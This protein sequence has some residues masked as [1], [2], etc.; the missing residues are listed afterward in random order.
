MSRL[1]RCAATFALCAVAVTAFTVAGWPR[2]RHAYTLELAGPTSVATLLDL[3]RGEELTWRVIAEATPDAPATAYWFVHDDGRLAGPWRPGRAVQPHGTDR[4][5]RLVALVETAGDRP[6]LE[7][8]RH[9]P[10][11]GR[12]ET[13]LTLPNSRPSEARLSRDLRTLAVAVGGD[14]LRFDIYDVETGQ[15]RARLTLPDRRGSVDPD[16]NTVAAL[17]WA[18]THDGSRLVL[19]EGWTG[20]KRTTP[21][22]IEVRDATTGELAQR[23]PH[24]DPM[25]HSWPPQ[26]EFGRQEDVG[27]VGLGLTADGQG[28]CYKLDW[29]RAGPPASWWDDP[30]LRSHPNMNCASLTTG[31]RIFGRYKFPRRPGNDKVMETYWRDDHP[32]IRVANLESAD[33]F[34]G[35]PGTQWGTWLVLASTEPQSRS[36]WH[37]HHQYR[38]VPGRTRPEV[39]FRVS[40]TDFNTDPPVFKWL[41]RRQ[42]Q[43]TPYRTVTRY[44]YHDATSG[45]ATRFE[46][47]IRFDRVKHYEHEGNDTF[48]VGP[49]DLAILVNTP[50]AGRAELTIWE[51]PPRPSPYPWRWSVPGGITL[52]LA[53]AAVTGFCRWRGD[54][55]R[56]RLWLTGTLRRG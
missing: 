9:D 18:V 11:T 41:L 39:V 5:G 51:L 28:V 48:A 16:D 40:D 26:P 19:T 42:Q 33:A 25:R 7:V 49:N 55:S 12:A 21:E 32:L 34:Q 20:P 2:P 24:G 17:E 23:I 52:G 38:P 37:S 44:T 27:A 10:A 22:G 1:T 46:G 8:V 50:D 13:A 31:E 15:V 43:L 29:R 3:P 4:A 14:S 56:L 36:G 47:A 6:P 30:V 45:G 54:S 35:L 53:V